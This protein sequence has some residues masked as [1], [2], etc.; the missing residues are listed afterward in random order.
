MEYLMYFHK[1]SAGFVEN[2]TNVLVAS[3]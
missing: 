3:I 1:I 2:F